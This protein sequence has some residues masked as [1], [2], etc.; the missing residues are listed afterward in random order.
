MSDDNSRERPLGTR[1]PSA[2]ATQAGVA[3]EKGPKRGAAARTMIGL[4]VIDPTQAQRIARAGLSGRPPVSSAPP[5]RVVHS[6]PPERVIPAPV[7]AA[8]QADE[9][10]DQRDSDTRYMEPPSEV[11]GRAQT[12]VVPP[13]QQPFAH[14][15]E[16]PPPPVGPFSIPVP[17]PP[18]PGPGLFGS[19]LQRASG[20][21]ARAQPRVP[22]AANAGPGLISSSLHAMH[23]PEAPKPSA[24][25]TS[26]ST[27]QAPNQAPNQAPDAWR[28][29]VRRMAERG[30]AQ[31]PKVMPG[32]TASLRLKL[33]GD[34]SEEQPYRAPKSALPGLLLWLLILGGLGAGAY[35]YAESQGGVTA[36]IERLRGAR[37]PA[38]APGSTAPGA[39]PAAPP[40]AAQQPAAAPQVEPSAAQ[41]Q[42]PAAAP[43]QAPAAAAPG[44]PAAAPPTAAPTA[45]TAPTADDGARSLA[46]PDPPQDTPSQAP[47]AA[48][49]AA[50]NSPATPTKAAT[51]S[52]PKAQSKPKASAKPVRRSEPVVKVRPLEGSSPSSPSAAPPAPPDMPYVPVPADPPAP[53]EPR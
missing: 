28:D 48:P 51:P 49:P 29:D 43:A 36:V 4:P 53:D 41:P 20:A 26:F 13:L 9:P 11:L 50:A 35:F 19:T 23:D 15:P 2:K 6:A 46:D 17:P 14:V 42:Q 3:P 10:E 25:R 24:P 5:E 8:S 18:D 40:T 7:P 32:P 30:P 44:D 16:A 31:R 52:K 12:E 37:G 27:H 33:E 21:G 45:P 39:V 22:P 47:A 34:I 38:L 1:S